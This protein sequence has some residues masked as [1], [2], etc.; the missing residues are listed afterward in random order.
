MYSCTV[1]FPLL[2]LWQ[3]QARSGTPSTKRNQSGTGSKSRLCSEFP[4]LNVDVH[5]LL[6]R[7]LFKTESLSNNVFQLEL[8]LQ[9]VGASHCQVIQVLRHLDHFGGD[10]D[11]SVR[12][13]ALILRLAHGGHNCLSDKEKFF[14]CPLFQTW[15]ADVEF[16]CGFA[17]PRSENG[18]T[19]ST[20]CESKLKV[21]AANDTSRLASSSSVA[22][23]RIFCPLIIS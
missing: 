5:A 2:H 16:T 9:A 7:H 10:Q 3:V 18:T 6:P 15:H 13:T 1:T 8:G 4:H 14:F 11:V 12:H 19:K 23:S 20:T 22:S 17:S 21:K